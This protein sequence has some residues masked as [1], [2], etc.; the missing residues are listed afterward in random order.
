MSII[1]LI[2][3]SYPK[4][5]FSVVNLSVPIRDCALQNIMMD[6]TPMY[7]GGYHPLL[8]RRRRDGTGNAKHYS[9]TLKPVNYYVVDF[10]LSWKYDPLTGP[11]LAHIIH[12]NDRTVPEFEGKT[13]NDTYNPFPT[14]VYYLGNFVKEEFLDVSSSLILFTFCYS[15]HN[16]SSRNVNHS[17]FCAAWSTT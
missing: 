11:P 4:S 1:M 15:Y 12:G 7:P 17:N 6:V 9:R 3:L 13:N 5:V 14:D 2:G 16:H 8:E 10:G